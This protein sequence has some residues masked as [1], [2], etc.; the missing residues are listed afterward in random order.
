MGDEEPRIVDEIVMKC[1]DQLLSDPEVISTSES[2]TYQPSRKPEEV[3]SKD[4]EA[5]LTVVLWTVG[6]LRARLKRQPNPQIPGFPV[7]LR[8]AWTGLL[9]GRLAFEKWLLATSPSDDEAAL[10]HFETCIATT[11]VLDTAGRSIETTMSKTGQEK[12]FG[13]LSNAAEGFSER[14][15][16]RR[17]GR[18][19]RP[20]IDV[21]NDNVLLAVWERVNATL[22]ARHQKDASKIKATA[23]SEVK[24]EDDVKVDTFASQ[25]A[26]DLKCAVCWD[27]LQL[28]GMVG[29]TQ[30]EENPLSSNSDAVKMPQCGHTLCAECTYQWLKVSLSRVLLI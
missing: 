28:S 5:M 12:L 18:R 22:T 10:K 13:M 15:V 9:P 20:V 3:T 19:R 4:V 21:H 14:A 24:K 30:D 29:Q 1:M 7:H 6:S 11:L 27:D 16:M 8:H 17:K 2:E 23:V 25:A 26:N